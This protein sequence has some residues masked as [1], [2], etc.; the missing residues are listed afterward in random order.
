MA[1]LLA[2]APMAKADTV[3]KLTTRL[4]KTYHQCQ[5]ATVHPD[6]ISF[7]HSNGA[8]KVLFTDL[9]Q[10][11]RDRFG[12][13]P[14]EAAAYAK[15]RADKLEAKK[16]RAAQARIELAKV[17]VRAQ[18]ARLQLLQSRALAVLQAQQIGFGGGFGGPVPAVGW[19]GLYNPAF[20]SA[21]PSG[22]TYGGHGYFRRDR[23]ANRGSVQL[24]SPIYDL[25]SAS[26]YNPLTFSRNR[27]WSRYPGGHS[28]CVSGAW[29][30]YSPTLGSYQPG[31][32][33]QQGGF[34][35]G[36]GSSVS[37]IRSG[38]GAGFSGSGFSAGVCAPAVSRGPIAP[39]MSVGH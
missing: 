33:T 7:F 10:G 27:S 8:A 11:W 14:S 37:G 15:E 3:A 26:I 34:Y 12:Y 4:G 30:H 13:D 35:L 18:E 32:F 6:G 5:I 36:G 20:F 2:L 1:L 22:I 9:D 29:Y 21:G 25:A 28:A 23:N 19:P 39:P 31:Q 24:T 38:Y 16:E 17:Q